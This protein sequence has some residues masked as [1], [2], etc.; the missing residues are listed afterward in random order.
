M[1]AQTWSNIADL[2]TPFPNAKSQDITKYMIQQVS[3]QPNMFNIHSELIYD[4]MLI[5]IYS[6]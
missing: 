6:I 3:L 1:W 4:S 5:G 2:A